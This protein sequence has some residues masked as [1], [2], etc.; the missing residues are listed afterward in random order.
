VSNFVQPFLPLAPFFVVKDGNSLAASIANRHYSRLWRGNIKQDR[1]IGPGQ[2]MILVEPS[3]KWLFAWRKTIFRKDEQEGVECCI[4]R[5]ESDELSSNIIL[6]AEKQWDL[7]Y[8]KSRK[9][10]YVNPRL[11]K[12]KNPGF[13]F[14]RAGW[15]KHKRVSSRGLILLF[16]D[17]CFNEVL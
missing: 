11:I 4:F 10:T 13:C 17:A 6:I 14:K 15:E 1:I 12:S 7:A 16:K 2:R 9:F 5:N 3:G 8:G